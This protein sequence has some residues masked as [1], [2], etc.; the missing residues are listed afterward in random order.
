MKTKVITMDQ[1][2]KIGA[3]ALRALESEKITSLSQLSKY[4]E[5]ELLKLHG[6]GPKALKIVEESLAK[7]GLHFVN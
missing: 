7:N 5:S 4:S 6:F 3:P 1:L 2:P